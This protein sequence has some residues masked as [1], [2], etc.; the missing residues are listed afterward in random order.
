MIRDVVLGYPFAISLAL[1]CGASA[2]FESWLPAVAFIGVA[3]VLGSFQRPVIPIALAFLG[4]LLDT[5]GMTSMK[6]LGLPLTMSKASVVF[7]LGAHFVHTMMTRKKLFVMTPVTYGVFAIIM[8]MTMSL[9]TAVDPS[10]GYSDMAGVIMLAV[11]LHLIYTAIGPDD[12][13]WLMRTMSAMAICVFM[14]TLFTQ[15]KQGF[16]VT[17]DHAWQQRTSGAFGDPNA[18]CTALLVLCPILIGALI[19]DEHWVATPLLLLLGAT[20][21]ACIV[22]S[23]SRAG[24]LSAVIISPGIFYMLRER[25]FLFAGSMFGLLIILPFIINIDAA[26]LRYQTLLDPTLE[27]DLGHGSLRER[28]ALLEAGINIFLANPVLGVGVGLFRMHASYVSAGEV[29]K[30]AHNSYVNVAAEQGVPG[31]ITHVYLLFLMWKSAWDTANRSNSLYLRSIGIGYL[32]SLTAF[33]A[34]AATLNLVTFAL[35]WFMLGLGLV[36]GRIGGAERAITFDR[37]VLPTS[38]APMLAETA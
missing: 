24:L 26:L 27:A 12:L 34:M 28:K 10:L 23:M 6:I 38:T 30:I 37:H 20:F 13:P 32:M 25:K 21:P 35:A 9:V 17:L 36:A 33:C 5:R 11:M 29:W 22:Q 18:W 15:R 1:V 31:L 3:V 2:L 19:V 7:A 14:W 4:I 16:F 8:T